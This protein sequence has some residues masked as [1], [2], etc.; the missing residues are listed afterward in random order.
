MQPRVHYG[1]SRRIR[2][3]QSV[4]NDQSGSGDNAHPHCERESQ[5]RWGHQDRTSPSGAARDHSLEA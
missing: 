5:L 4:H 3:S 2:G 1:S